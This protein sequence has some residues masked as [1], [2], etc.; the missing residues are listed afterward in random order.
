[1]T[2]YLLLFD[3]C[4]LDFL[5]AISDERTSLSSVY[6]V[7]P[8]QRSISRVPVPWGSWLYF[9]VSDLRLPSSSL[10]TTR[11]V[12]V[13]VFDPAST[14]LIDGVQTQSYV[15]SDGQSASLSWFRAPIWGLRPD[16][17]YCQTLA[18][19]FMWGFLSDERLGFPFII[20][21]GPR[22]CSV[23]TF[24]QIYYIIFNAHYMSLPS[25]S[26]WII[27]Q[28]FS[29]SVNEKNYLLSS[30]NADVQW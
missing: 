3:R 7:G 30:L 14:C 8:R 12:T 4:G 19:F 16:F 5:G 21:A 29:E 15:T 9:T 13:E 6:A 26:S 17:Y 18:C 23:E 11:R 28:R 2:R 24:E 27:Q 25:S 1:M 22:Q 20:A 10:P